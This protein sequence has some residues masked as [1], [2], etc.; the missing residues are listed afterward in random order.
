MPA[1]EIIPRI[2][3]GDA[4]AAQDIG[5]LRKNK[6]VAVVNATNTVPNYYPKNFRYF[7]IPINDP[8]PNQTLKNI[9]VRTMAVMMPSVLD[10]IYSHHRKGAI[11]I[12]CRAGIQRS[13]AIM[14]G[15]LMKYAHN[16]GK[17]LSVEDAVKIVRSRRPMV[18]YWG[19]YVNF[20][21][22]LQFLKLHHI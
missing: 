22:A 13:A 5:F 12:H 18:F 3:V 15:F 19:N 9:N 4:Q 10:F 14:T 1:T 21:D 17:R 16:N 7:N 20:K 2:W 6:I 11:L 8:G